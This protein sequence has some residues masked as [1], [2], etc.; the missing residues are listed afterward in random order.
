[1]PRPKRKKPKP[2][3]KTGVGVLVISTK[4]PGKMLLVTSR[5]SKSWAL[6]K[7]NIDRS[8]G[9][10]ESARR[11]AF[12]EAGVRGRMSSVP[13]GSYI[14]HKSTGDVFRVR[15]FKM[16]VRT[17]LAEWPEKKQRQRRWVSVRSA[18]KL[19]ANSGLRRLIGAQLPRA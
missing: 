9:P 12:E 5:H 19:I 10:L 14:H 1:M 2:R 16:H 7:G 15:V 4:K 13:I 8:L 6:A 17:E 3:T 18:L 11:E